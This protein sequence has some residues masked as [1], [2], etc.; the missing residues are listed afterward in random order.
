M[1]LF[2]NLLCKLLDIPD[3]ITTCEYVY[4]Y[5]NVS[6]KLNELS[7]SFNK[8]INELFKVRQELNEYKKLEDEGKLVTLP[9]A[10][11]Q[12]VYYRGYYD[13]KVYKGTVEYVL[14]NSATFCINVCRCNSVIRDNFSEDDIGKLVFF[15]KDTA[16]IKLATCEKELCVDGS[17]T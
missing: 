5:T 2:K 8:A 11:G 14:V 17:N 6:N 15:D 13:E 1:M 12:T 9:I 16:N 4:R 10:I 3:T 7:K